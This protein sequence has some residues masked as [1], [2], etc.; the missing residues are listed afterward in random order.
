MHSRLL[1]KAS[2]ARCPWTSRPCDQRPHI[3][4]AR[5]QHQSQVIPTTH[6][7]PTRVE[8]PAHPG[9][10]GVGLLL[11]DRL[12]LARLEVLQ[13]G[14][15]LSGGARGDEGGR[16][17]FARTPAP[18]ACGSVRGGARLEVPRFGAHPSG[19]ARPWRAFHRTLVSFSSNSLNCA[20]DVSSSFW[21]DAQLASASRRWVGGGHHKAHGGRAW[22]SGGARPGPGEST[23]QIR[24]GRSASA[25]RTHRAMLCNTAVGCAPAKAVPAAP[26]SPP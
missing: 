4:A 25:V 20:C 24:E 19:R 18:D 6:A 1:H 3:H 17:G 7:P 26:S 8:T 5:V 16:G 10:G 15:H 12:L 13:V 23:Q 14:A 2:P 9:L 22:Q 21:I 11:G